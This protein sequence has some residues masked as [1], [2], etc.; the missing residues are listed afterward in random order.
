MSDE[1]SIDT[2]QVAAV[3][4]DIRKDAQGGFADAAQR[5]SRLHGYGVEWGTKIFHGPIADA[6]DKYVK[7]LENTEANL[8]TYPKAASALAD[9]AEQIARDFADADMNSK[10]VQDK[11]ESL[12]TGAITNARSLADKEQANAIYGLSPWEVD[13]K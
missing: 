12:L 4:S 8:R 5:A 10:A 7:A 1:V 9:V 2:D 13:T 3:G 11:I 6:K